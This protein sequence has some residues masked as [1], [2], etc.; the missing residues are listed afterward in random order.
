MFAFLAHSSAQVAGVPDVSINWLAIL[1]ATVAAMAIGWVWYGP[2][3]G[4]RWMNLVKLSKKETEKAWKK[5]MAT[6][7]VMAFVQAYVMRH[8]VIYTA[9][10]YPDMSELGV[11]LMTGLWAFIG[12]A[13]PLILSNNMFARRPMELSYV[14]AGNQLVTL[15]VIGAIVSTVN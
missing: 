12:F 14:E 9:Y 4:D 6:M 11:G 8:L 3:F 13:L 10:F 1:L 7:V 15:L 5:P 2:A